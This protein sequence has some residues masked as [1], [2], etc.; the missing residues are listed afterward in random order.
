MSNLHLK[1]MYLQKQLN[2]TDSEFYWFLKLVN[3]K[4]IIST[5][6]IINN[7]IKYKEVLDE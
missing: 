4:G 6:D 3:Y 7:E 2:M 1:L 5:T